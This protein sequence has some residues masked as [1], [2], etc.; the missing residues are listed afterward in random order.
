MAKSQYGD[1]IEQTTGKLFSGLWDSYNDQLF[2]D[3]VSLFNTRLDLSGFDKNWF[4]D[5]VCLDAGCGGG[6]ATIGMARFGAKKVV[7][8]D[9]ED[10]L[11]SFTKENVEKTPEG[12]VMDDLGL[13]KYCCRRHMLSHVDIE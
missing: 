9:L 4:K 3:S 1:S 10:K 11:I 8:I 13:T 5:K 6:R 2:E 7:G 12:E